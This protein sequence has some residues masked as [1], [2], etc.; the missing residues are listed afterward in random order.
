MLPI[1]TIIWLT[2]FGCKGHILLLR[3]QQVILAGLS[4]LVLDLLTGVNKLPLLWPFSTESFKLSFGLLPSAGGINL[5]NYF[6]Y[7][8]LLIEVGV[9]I[10][11]VIITYFINHFEINNR[12]KIITLI[13]LGLISICFMV[14]AFGLER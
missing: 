5:F 9:L 8:N 13:G 10:P 12:Q 2:F 7:R 6:L 4:H 11:L 1:C 14:W 3:S